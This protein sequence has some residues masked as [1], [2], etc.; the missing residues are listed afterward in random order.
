MTRTSSKI[1]S[2]SESTSPS[3][4]K[5][6]VKAEIAARAEADLEFFISLVHPQTV[7][8]LVHKELISWMT[9]QEANTHQ[10]VLLP[11]DHQKSRMAGYRV[12]WEIVKNP[13]IRVIGAQPEDGAAQQTQR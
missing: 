4:L 1:T 9:R 6:R 8:G 13:A 5:S 2:D 10:L 11:R 12:A 7:L 3:S